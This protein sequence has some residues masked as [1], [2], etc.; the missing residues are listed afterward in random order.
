ML[1][2]FGLIK[3]IRFQFFCKTSFFTFLKCFFFLIFVFA[4]VVVVVVS[5]FGGGGEETRRAR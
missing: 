5:F 4:V 3:R 2:V 1:L